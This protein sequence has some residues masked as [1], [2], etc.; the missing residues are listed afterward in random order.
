MGRS[1]GQCVGR[2][3]TLKTLNFFVK[4]LQTHFGHIPVYCDQEEYLRAVVHSTAGRVCMPTGVTAVGK[5]L[6]NG[7]AEQRVRALRERRSGVDV[8]FDH[9]WRSGP[10]DMR[11][12]VNGATIEIPPP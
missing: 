6:E 12:G 1:Q 10:C 2:V 5:S 7:C 9:L 4:M 11:N 3:R 8:I